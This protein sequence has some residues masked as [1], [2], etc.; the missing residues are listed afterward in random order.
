M[1][2]WL[3]KLTDKPHHPMSSR[4][5]AEA[6]LDELPK[7]NPAE[8][9]EEITDWLQSVTD[10]QHFNV[11]LRT[12]VIKLLD[13][14]G[15]PVYA[16]L[17]RS[18][19][20]SPSLQDFQ[21]MAAWKVMR[22]FTIELI[23]GYE[24]CLTA[25]NNDEDPPEDLTDELALLCTRQLR[26]CTEKLKL[27]LMRYI[28]IDHATWEHMF[29]S[30]RKAELLDY[31]GLTVYPY[32]G[33]GEHT[34]PKQELMRALAIFVASP[35]NLTPEEIEVCSRI[36]ARM[37][38]S[39]DFSKSPDIS[40][41]YHIDLENPRAPA[42]FDDS[43]IP[44]HSTRYFSP[45]RAL[46]Q[47]S[48]AI[49]QIEDKRQSEERRFGNEFSPQGKLHV[50]KHLMLH[51][52]KRFPRR[53]FERRNI[54]VQMEIASGFFNICYLVPR[55]DPQPTFG[56]SAANAEAL[57]KRLSSAAGSGRKP[58]MMLTSDASLNGVGGNLPKSAEAWAK[59]GSLCALHARNVPNWWVGVIRRMGKAGE[60]EIHA[61][62]E[63]LN[64]KSLSVWLRHLETGSDPG[65]EWDSNTG[66]FRY[67]Y[68][69]GILVPDSHNSFQEATLILEKG[70]YGP[71]KVYEV[72]IG[73]TPREIEL[74]SL[75]V[76]GEDYE[77]LDFNWML[78]SY[79]K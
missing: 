56:L 65:A 11:H 31:S 40:S 54:S 33:L 45:I 49:Q 71:G 16:K 23:R 60:S 20:L 12:D 51:W 10:N 4:E 62:I 29:H 72:L 24:A 61:G 26:A 3:S 42:P 32:R 27:E 73:D 43:V 35:G 52:G 18:Y 68:I 39:F 7:I 53:A 25:W 70:H 69:P 13:E 17:L 9:L 74:S 66:S 8:T 59:V 36:S 50:L 28:E 55:Q 2:S 58:V 22:Q 44:T 77:W 76:D 75:R 57:V 14:S 63:I 78:A 34:T 41:E 15:Q 48:S 5:K 79:Q 6:I 19:L 38:G 21:G 37:A 47:V 30:F 46:Q 67:S 1:L 64:K